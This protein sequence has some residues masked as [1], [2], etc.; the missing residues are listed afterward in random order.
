MLRKNNKIKKNKKFIFLKLI[1]NTSAHTN[2]FNLKRI[3]PESKKSEWVIGEHETISWED[4]KI[5][6]ALHKTGDVFN[7]FITPWELFY[8]IDDLSEELKKLDARRP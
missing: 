3:D 4:K 7:K 1:K 6:R 8:L 5:T 2:K